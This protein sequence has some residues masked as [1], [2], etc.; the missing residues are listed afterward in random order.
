MMGCIPVIL[1]EVQELAFEELVDWDSFAVW[2]R[3][4]DIAGLDNLLRSMPESEIRERRAA[5]KRVWRGLW[6]AEGGL[7]NEA[8]LKSL[9]TRKYKSPPRRHFSASA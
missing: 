7:A 6:Y 5:M 3:P 2:V 4:G 9:H 8:I 1:S